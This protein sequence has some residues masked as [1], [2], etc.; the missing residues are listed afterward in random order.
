MSVVE[1]KA[2]AL[3]T[4]MI[5]LPYVEGKVPYFSDITEQ[6]EYDALRKDIRQFLD[7]PPCAY[8]NP[9]CEFSGRHMGCCS[10]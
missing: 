7:T 4:R 1:R 10:D 2:H 5:A 8:G 6:E 9:N 3:L